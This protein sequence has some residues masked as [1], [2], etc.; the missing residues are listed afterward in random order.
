MFAFRFEIKLLP[1]DR[2]EINHCI[3]NRAGM[4]VLSR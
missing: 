4:V 1:G 2:R 3:E